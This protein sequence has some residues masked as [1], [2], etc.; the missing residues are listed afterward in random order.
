VEQKARKWDM[1]YIR[2]IFPTTRF[3]R[4]KNVGHGGLAPFHPDKLVKGIRMLCE[5]GEK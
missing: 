5:R 4:F 1:D 2:K 3:V